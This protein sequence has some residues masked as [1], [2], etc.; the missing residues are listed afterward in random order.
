MGMKEERLGG[1][2]PEKTIRVVVKEGMVRALVKG[3]VY[4]S[5]ESGD[6][7]SQRMCIVQLYENGAGNQEELAGAFGVHVNTVQKYRSTSA[8]MHAKGS[9]DW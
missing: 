1:W 2:D 3:H 8:I 4:M 9:W 6:E 5:W 7:G